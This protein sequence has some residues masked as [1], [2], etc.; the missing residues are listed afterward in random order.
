M[1]TQEIDALKLD[2]QKFNAKVEKLEKKMKEL[3]EK[4]NGYYCYYF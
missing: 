2:N 4:E 1:A 3:K